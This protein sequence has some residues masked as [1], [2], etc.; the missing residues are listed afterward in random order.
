LTKKNKNP[1][2]KDTNNSK[3]FAYKSNIQNNQQQEFNKSVYRALDQTK[4][5][6]N[7]S[8]Q[9]S[10]NQIP[11]YNNIVNDYQ[12]QTLQAVKEITE[13]FIE[14]QKTIIRSIQSSWVHIN[15]MLT[16][17][18]M[19]GTLLKQLPMHIADL[20]AMLQTIQ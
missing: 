15:K 12:E 1:S 5:N 2:N 14:S 20:L 4:D 6:V 9:Q 19:H 7:R 13:N 11:Q 10:R 3:G 8:I 18:S 16:L 17:L